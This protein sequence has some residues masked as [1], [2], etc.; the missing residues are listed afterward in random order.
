[1]PKNVIISALQLSAIFWSFE[2]GLKNNNTQSYKI[3]WFPFM[4]CCRAD[5]VTFLY[6]LYPNQFLRY[7]AEWKAFKVSSNGPSEYILTGRGKSP[8]K[9][10]YSIE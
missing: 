9:F 7:Y 10:P 2:T 5:T 4:M 3:E 1:M 8:Y 6:F